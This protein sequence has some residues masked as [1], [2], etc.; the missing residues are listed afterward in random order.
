MTHKTCSTD[1]RAVTKVDACLGN[2]L[3]VSGS[4][5][6]TDT[7]TLVGRGRSSKSYGRSN[8]IDRYRSSLGTCY[9]RIV[10]SIDR[11]C[12]RLTSDTSRTVEV[13][14]RDCCTENRTI[15]K[16]DAI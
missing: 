16:D 4:E 7:S 3:V 15:I 2:G 5:A 12:E 8:I 14:H 1:A 6:D 9:T 11:Y 10:S 13:T